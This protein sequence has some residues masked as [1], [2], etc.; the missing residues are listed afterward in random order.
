MAFNFQRLNKAVIPTGDSAS[1]NQII[2]IYRRAIDAINPDLTNLETADW[3]ALVGDLKG[4][5]GFLR[6]IFNPLKAAIVAGA[7]Q[8]ESSLARAVNATIRFDITDPRAIAYAEDRVGELIAQVTDEIKQT[9]RDVVARAYREGRT[10]DQIAA[11]LRNSIGLHDRWARAVENYQRRQFEQL[12]KTMPYDTA[13]QKAAALAEKYRARLI[14]KRAMTIARTETA[15]ASMYGRYLS[16]LQAADSGLIDPYTTGKRWFATRP[17]DVCKKL[18]GETVGML[19]P[20]STGKLMPPQHPNCKCRAVIIPNWKE[21]GR[22]VPVQK[23]YKRKFATREEAARF[24]ANARWGGKKADAP[25]ST[26]TAAAE[27]TNL[28]TTDA[29]AEEW[30]RRF[31]NIKVDLVGISPDVANEAAAAFVECAAMF[32][33]VAARIGVIQGSYMSAQASARRPVWDPVSKQFRS[34]MIRVSSAYTKEKF[35]ELSKTGQE[36]GFFV[37]GSYDPSRIVNGRPM[38]GVRINMTHEFGHHVD[39]WLRSM[40]SEYSLNPAGAKDHDKFVQSTKLKLRNEYNRQQGSGSKAGVKEAIGKSISRYAATNN[41]ELFAESFQEFYTSAN[42]RPAARTVVESAFA[43]MGIPVPSPSIQKAYQR[44]YATRE[45]A[46]RAAAN[47]RWGNRTSESDTAETAAVEIEPWVDQ[48]SVKDVN[49]EFNKRWGDRTILDLTGVSPDAANGIADGLNELLTLYPD[50]ELHF[51]GTE[52]VFKDA[53]SGRGVSLPPSLSQERKKELIELGKQFGVPP[54][55][56]GVAGSYITTVQGIRINANLVTPDNAVQFAVSSVQSENNR[57]YTPTGLMG[58]GK[59]STVVKEAAKRTLVHEFAHAID[60]TGSHPFGM[61]P[62]SKRIEGLGDPVSRA[63]AGTPIT[64]ESRKEFIGYYVGE[65]ASTNPPELFA[66][67]FTEYHLN[68]K[69]RKLSVDQAQHVMKRAN[70]TLAQPSMSNG[71]EKAYK[72]KYATR[73][74][75]AQ[76]A[77]RARWGNRAP[78]QDG[79]SQVYSADFEPWEKQ[80]GH[81]EIEAEM[82]RRF[83]HLGW[84]FR[85]LNVDLAN[86]VAASFVDLAD[87]YPEVAKRIKN[88]GDELGMRDLEPASSGYPIKGALGDAANGLDQAATPWIRINGQY[89]ALGFDDAAITGQATGFKVKG[90]FDL[91]RTLNGR[92][93]S[94]VRATITHEFGHHVDYWLTDQFKKQYRLQGYEAELQR[95]QVKWAAARAFGGTEKGLSKY[96]TR[97]DRELFAEAFTEYQ[98]SDS[99]RGM[100]RRVIEDAFIGVGLPVPVAPATIITKAYQRKYATR[101]EAAR[102]AAN[103]RWGGSATETT[104]EDDSYR[105]SHQPSEVG[106]RAHDLTEDG[107]E[108]EYLTDDVYAHPERYSGAGSTVVR[109]TMAQLKRAKGN[110]DAIVTIHRWAPEGNVIESGNWVSLSKTYAEQHGES[111]ASGKVGSVISL[112]VPAKTIRFAG[113]DLAEFGY[114]PSSADA[115]VKAYKRKYA[116][117]AEA[118]RAAA[119]ARWGNRAVGYSQKVQTERGGDTFE[120]DVRTTDVEPFDA[121]AFIAAAAKGPVSLVGVHAADRLVTEFHNDPEGMGGGWL[122]TGT[123]ASLIDPS[124]SEGQGG[125]SSRAG[126]ALLELTL[127]KPLILVQGKNFRGDQEDAINDAIWATAGIKP[128]PETKEYFSYKADEATRREL[129]NAGYDGIVLIKKERS[130]GVSLG[131]Q[132]VVFDAGSQIKIIDSNLDDTEWMRVR[133]TG[134]RAPL[135][136]AESVASRFDG[137]GF[138]LVELADLFNPSIRKAY[139][140]KYATRAEAARA[141]ANARWGNRSGYSQGAVTSQRLEPV[142]AE[143]IGKPDTILD[144]IL[145]ESVDPFDADAFMEAVE[146]GP[147]SLIGVHA[148][149]AHGLETSV[150]FGDEPRGG[151]F[152]GPGTYSSIIDEYGISEQEKGYQYRGRQVLLQ[153]S[154]KKPVVLDRQDFIGTEAGTYND[155]LEAAVAKVLQKK[156]LSEKDSPRWFDAFVKDYPQGKSVSNEN[157]P[158]YTP[159]FMDYLKKNGHD[160]IVLLD[161]SSSMVSVFSGKQIK[162]IDPVLTTEE[163]QLVYAAG[164]STAAKSEVAK[165][166]DHAFDGRDF[167]LVSIEDFMA[168]P[169][170]KMSRSEAGR[171]AANVRWGNR[172]PAIASID[173]VSLS[174]GQKITVEGKQLGNLTINMVDTGIDGD[175]RNVHIPGYALFDGANMGLRREQMPQ[176][177]ARV[178]PQFLSEMRLKGVRAAAQSVD[179]RT[180][181]PSQAD[182]SAAKTGEILKKMRDGS[183]HD[184]PA[185]RIL[186]SKDGFVI[187]GHHRWA[188]ASAYAF[189]FPNARLP[190][191]RVDLPA[192]DLIPAAREFG[193]REGIKTLGFGET[194]KKAARWIFGS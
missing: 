191:I 119:N 170:A 99:P 54:M 42:P 113:D 160:G 74:E 61:V 103:A 77:A 102:A 93:L 78:K 21:S 192:A 135:V 133:D 82:R 19:Q 18:N 86:E 44:K 58:E 14:R 73:R 164:R 24:A 176:V 41:R 81:P 29:V 23:A 31:P 108:G 15:Q 140:R 38:T 104:A 177:P 59:L 136:K 184:S 76:A 27:W 5:E 7:A 101:E 17:C 155:G 34:G 100:S 71:I 167:D 52:E 188:A 66:E 187:D 132:V 95:N 126:R 107:G 169:I 156:G 96:A 144:E 30:Q 171:Y 121:N 173:A 50:T 64:P 142:Q 26:S 127:K 49:R 25:G 2:D 91:D 63:M 190:I 124:G 84:S 168:E 185:G 60:F 32:P 125:Y 69:P 134:Q 68:P 154:L 128:P 130:P 139:K 115:I 90:I 122:G 181:K 158:D 143:V 186:V 117:R 92:S 131:S 4:F 150:V 87:Q 6:Q 157:Y 9:V 65:Y 148:T 189:E 48:Q 3:T 183:F 146:K 22:P 147:V 28:P 51:V 57:F 137:D 193:A 8:Q 1:V 80:Q 55:G 141:A 180:L 35:D 112:D 33:E 13:M 53:F 47:A 178:K 116:T 151:G 123:Y 194:L 182:I 110:P 88:V 163:R 175:L 153:V 75:A 10:I 159:G 138:D 83:P 98:L 106:P 94:G 118:A 43:N 67:V 166:A 152:L 114:W 89:S 62:V 70:K 162:V 37:A 174:R 145:T 165:A 56:A 40:T 120:G 20:F 45:E 11:E 16:W 46:A 39:Y 72:R 161:S 97:N 79:A 12:V 109:E 111:N 105:M 179:P 129:K 85:Q 172:T 149:Y 36:S